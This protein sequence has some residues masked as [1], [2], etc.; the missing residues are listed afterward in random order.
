MKRLTTT[1]LAAF[2]HKILQYYNDHL[3]DKVDQILLDFSLHPQNKVL[4]YKR[5]GNSLYNPASYTVEDILRFIAM[6]RVL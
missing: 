1:Q 4:V 5:R 3:E 6:D 2:Q